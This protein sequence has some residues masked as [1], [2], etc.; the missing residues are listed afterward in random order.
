MLAA[1]VVPVI[2]AAAVPILLMGSEDRA[3]PTATPR[4]RRELR[5]GWRFELGPPPGPL[6]P[7]NH[8]ACP[9]SQ[10]CL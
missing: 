3:I 6:V 4:S 10:G 5:A 8:S 7:L 1:L 9:V 2:V